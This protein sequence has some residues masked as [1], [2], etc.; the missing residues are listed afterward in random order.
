MKN[1]LILASYTGQ[2]KRSSAERLRAI[3]AEFGISGLESK[4]FPKL[5]SDS[6]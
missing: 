2:R 3:L 6:N 5:G 4:R 1:E